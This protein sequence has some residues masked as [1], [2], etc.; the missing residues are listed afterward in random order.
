MDKGMKAQLEKFLDYDANY[1]DFEVFLDEINLFT[2]RCLTISKT[3]SA[4]PDFYNQG[5]KHPHWNR[6]SYF[7][8]LGIDAGHLPFTYLSN[9]P[10]HIADRKQTIEKLRTY[11]KD[12]ELEEINQ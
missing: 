12:M 8:R 7:T 5:S 10:K 9:S 11:L 2:L 1:T 4:S 6:H 3:L